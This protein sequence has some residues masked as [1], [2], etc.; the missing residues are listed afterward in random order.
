MSAFGSFTRKV[1]VKASVLVLGA[2]ISL[3][4]VGGA[5][6]ADVKFKGGVWKGEVGATV[7]AVY[8]QNGKDATV[9]GKLVKIEKSF[10]KI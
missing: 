6:A 7:R 1:S 2:C 3:A 4:S 5:F 10:I 9:E 8:L